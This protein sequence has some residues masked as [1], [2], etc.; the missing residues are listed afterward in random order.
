MSFDIRAVSLTTEVNALYVASWGR[1]GSHSVSKFVETTGRNEWTTEKR[2]ATIRQ[3]PDPEEVKKLWQIETDQDK[4]EAE[5]L[6]KEE[7]QRVKCNGEFLAYNRRP[8]KSW[9]TMPSKECKCALC[10]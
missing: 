7:K 1:Q 8:D 10:R 3:D 4:I 5:T 2:V 9:N 6:A